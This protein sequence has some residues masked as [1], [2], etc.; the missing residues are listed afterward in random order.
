MTFSCMAIYVNSSAPSK[1]SLGTLNGISQTTISVIRAIGPATATS[2][3]SLSVRKNILGG[4]FIYAIL[5]VTC[6]IAIY[7]SRWLKEEKRAYT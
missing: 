3:F 2:L 7:A 4:N 6:C 5:L 1:D